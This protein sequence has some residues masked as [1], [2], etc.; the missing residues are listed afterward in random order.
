MHSLSRSY[1]KYWQQF[2]SDKTKWKSSKLDMSQ[3]QALFPDLFS[4]E[5]L[6]SF[7]KEFGFI[8]YQ[9]LH[10]SVIIRRMTVILI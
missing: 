9:L 6:H 5:P 1:P 8:R 3:N 7:V 10:S 2:I 4:K